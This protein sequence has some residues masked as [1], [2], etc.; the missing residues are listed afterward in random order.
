MRAGAALRLDNTLSA[1][2]DP[3]RRK[4][5]DLL[6]SRPRRAGELAAEFDVSAPAISRHLRVL[7]TRGLIEEEHSES[8]ARVRVY[9]LR[10]E[11]FRDLHEW[12]D[13]VEAFWTDQL[14]AFKA[15]AEQ[16]GK[17]GRRS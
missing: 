4:V 11:P 17:K 16:R 7:R 6:R 15:H 14:G 13:E 10:P 8:D 12:L 1:L 3:T 2:A 9:R 5:V